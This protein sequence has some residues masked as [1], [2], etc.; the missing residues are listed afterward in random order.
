[1]MLLSIGVYGYV[2][3]GR[4]F[5]DLAKVNQANETLSTIRGLVAWIEKGRYDRVRFLA[6]HDRTSRADLQRDRDAVTERVQTLVSMTADNPEQQRILR[7]L[8]TLREEGGQVADAL[9]N[10]P[11]KVQ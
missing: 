11:I 5:D 6:S 9:I 8:R 4:S 10:Q 1:M 2:T 7:E 3:L